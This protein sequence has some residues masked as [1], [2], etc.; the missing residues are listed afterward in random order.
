MIERKTDEAEKKEAQENADFVHADKLHLLQ[1]RGVILPPL[2][3]LFRSRQCPE[4]KT[5]LKERHIANP[6]DVI[7][8]KCPKCDYEYALSS[9][10]GSGEGIF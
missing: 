9:G 10:R 4:C 1:C 5:K 7:L 8:L 6:T 3:P 2:H